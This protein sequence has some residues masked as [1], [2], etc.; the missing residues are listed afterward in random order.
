MLTGERLARLQQLWE[1]NEAHDRHAAARAEKR[2]TITPQTG[3]FLYQLSRTRR[4]RI[5][6]EIGT[7]SG[8]STL[9]LALAAQVH[10]GQVVSVDHSAH[11]VA[12][13]HANLQAFAL[14]PV[15]TLHTDDAF[16]VLA[17][18]ADESVDLLFLDADRQRYPGYWPEITRILA[19]GALLV[20]D[21]ALSH[22]EECAP[23]VQ[24]VLATRGYL[25]ET[26]PIGKGQ[27]VILKDL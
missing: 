13:A 27:F 15:V 8:Y 20:M 1:D 17:N 12:L 25:A 3:R 23:F 22:V 10:K 7:S 24:A 9:W 18:T 6:L 5:T 26:Y 16:A 21:N 4:A 2:L 11:K 19:P 14:E